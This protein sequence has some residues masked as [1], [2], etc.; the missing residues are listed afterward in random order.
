MMEKEELHEIIKEYLEENL[1]IEI[2]H[3]GDNMIEVEVGINYDTISK[4][5]LYLPYHKG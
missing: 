4:D 1:T 2:N 3:I 5:C